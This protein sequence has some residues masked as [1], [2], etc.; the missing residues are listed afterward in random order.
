MYRIIKDGSTLAT[1]D[2]LRYVKSQRNGVVINC[3][4][5]EAHGICV[6]DEFYHLPWLPT[7]PGAEAVTYEEF[8]GT[9]TIAELDTALLEA[10]YQKIIGGLEV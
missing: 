2:K 8:S 1:V 6:A 7:L 9:D 10:E 3:K 4:D 5:T